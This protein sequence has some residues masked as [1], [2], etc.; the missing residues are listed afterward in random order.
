[1]LRLKNSEWSK[2]DRGEVSY[3][4]RYMWN[5]KRNDTNELTDKR[6]SQT[7]KMNLQLPGGRESWG[8]WD[9]HVHTAVFKMDHQQ[10]P[11]IQLRELC[12]VLRGG[13]DGRGV[14]ENGHMYMHG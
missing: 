12:P 13:L 9:G 2:S 3:D 14:W 8:L 4:I 11:T 6:D 5:L 1:M 7:W 10:R